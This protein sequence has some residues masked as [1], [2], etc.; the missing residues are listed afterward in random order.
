MNLIEKFRDSFKNFGRE[1]A[2]RIG[3]QSYSYNDF[4]SIINKYRLLLESQGE[5]SVQQ[6]VGVLCNERI[7]TYAAIFA[8]WF[9]GGIFL[10]LNSGLPPA[11]LNELL[12]KYSLKIVFSANELPEGINRDN[13][14][15]L[16]DFTKVDIEAP[17][18]Y[19]WN[20]DDWMYILT[21]S[22][23]TGVPK[24]VPINL[25]NVEAFV[26][27]FLD[28]YP[29]LSGKD[30]F[31]QT[32]DLTADAAFTGYLIPLLLGATVYTVPSTGFK[33]LNVAKILAGQ[34]IT[35]I[36]VTPSLLACLRPFFHSLHFD[37]LKHFH[38]GGEALP[39]DVVEEWRGHIPN[40]E[41]S[42]VYG[43][44]E[45]TITAT[46]YKCAPGDKLRALNNVIS[47]GKALKH[48]EL[49]LAEGVESGSR[50]LLIA[51]EQVMENYLNEKKQPFHMLS[52]E[53]A[54]YYLTGDIVEVDEE[55]YLYY[56]GRKDEQV[57]LNG[58][59]VDLIEIENK[60]RSILNE[61][62]NI[63][64]TVIEKSSGLHDLVV[65][66]ESF[67][68]NAEDVLKKLNNILPRFKIPDKI[69][70]VDFFP[71]THSGKTDKK[72]LVM[73]Y[74]KKVKED[75]KQ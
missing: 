31:L 13:I 29:E 40:A 16:K 45:T 28:I 68:G 37:H 55:G 19:N 18:I 17:P 47:I 41:I 1:V 30:N 2:F 59:R 74:L 50:E 26:E 3:D 23:S 69:V 42:N 75:G 4:H 33:P 70:G 51:G 20:K 14:K 15:I 58:Y 38:F 64:A 65:F 6:P 25:K 39:A 5:F 54:K 60:V 8:I 73:N 27:G 66:I 11:V 44:T 7:E 32:Y 61:A 43:P 36:Q 52:P 56:C 9:S 24:S 34:P 12:E 21:T 67:N 72:T 49:Y 22:G 46:I 63:A 10:P 62:G 48:V 71:L 57:K 35:W 53:S